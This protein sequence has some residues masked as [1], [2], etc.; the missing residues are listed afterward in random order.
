MLRCTPCRVASSRIRH[1]GILP[2]VPTNRFERP[3]TTPV[4]GHYAFVWGDVALIGDAADS[5]PNGE[6]RPFTPKQLMTDPEQADATRA[7]LTALPVQMFGPGHSPA[8]ERQSHN[9]AN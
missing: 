8:V 6:L 2:T 4:D 7:M 5:M 1:V 3:D 9:D